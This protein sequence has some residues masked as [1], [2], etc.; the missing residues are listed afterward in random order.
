MIRAA[1]SW[2]TAAFFGVVF[3]ARRGYERQRDWGRA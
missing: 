1:F 2:G 3:I